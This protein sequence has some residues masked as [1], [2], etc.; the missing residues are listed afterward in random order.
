MDDLS[1]CLNDTG[2][3]CNINGYILNHFVYADDMCLVASS[4]KG[5][6]TLLDKCITYTQLHGIVYNSKKSVC[7][8][9]KSSK[10]K[11][12]NLPSVKLGEQILQYVTTYKYLGC[13][14]NGMLND[15]DDIKRT[16]RGIY[17][18][19]NMLSRKFYHCSFDTKRLLFQT[20]CTNFYCT[21]LWWSYT[22]ESLRKVCVAVLVACLLVLKLMILILLGE[23]PYTA[24]LVV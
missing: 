18:R 15:N 16:L 10:Y 21:Q 14:I 1:I 24:L 5:L 2:I 9:I 11:L 6:Q 17:A 12:V 13:I 20:Y 3:G 8:C 19:A 23:K 4:A 7:M 22:Q